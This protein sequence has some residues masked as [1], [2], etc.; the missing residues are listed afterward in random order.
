MQQPLDIKE[1]VVLAVGWRWAVYSSRLCSGGSMTKEPVG[2]FPRRE[3]HFPGGAVETRAALTSLSP[4]LSAGTMTLYLIFCAQILSY[5]G[6]RREGGRRAR[7]KRW[8]QRE[9]EIEEGSCARAKCQEWIWE[10]LHK[11]PLVLLSGVQHAESGI[12]ACFRCWL[13]AS[14]RA[15]DLEL[16]PAVSRWGWIVIFRFHVSVLVSSAVSH[17]ADLQISLTFSESRAVSENTGE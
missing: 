3:Y 10:R 13:L 15:L 17:P 11:A 12:H 2:V 5:R 7:R 14:H 8:K 16:H 4:H 6:E 1:L 9:T